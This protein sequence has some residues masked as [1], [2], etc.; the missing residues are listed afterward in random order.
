[1]RRNDSRSSLFI[2]VRSA[3][4]LAVLIAP[5]TFILSAPPAHASSVPLYS[6][7]GS[8]GAQPYAGLVQDS[9]GGFYGTTINGGA[10]N[11]GTVFKITPTVAPTNK[12]QCK[13]GG[14]KTF[15]SP[16]TFK[17][18]GDCIHYVNTGQ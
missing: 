7:N 17:N 13:S 14:W 10:S 9:D 15:I 8:D 12:D 6:F 3:A 2:I 18:Q 11:Y 5:A 16:R 1:M 4:V